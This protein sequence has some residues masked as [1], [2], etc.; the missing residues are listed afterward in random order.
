MDKQEIISLLSNLGLTSYEAKAYV[1][2]L[3][4]GQVNANQVATVAGIPRP[5]IY[6]TIQSL[7]D[8]GL[9]TVIPTTPTE[10]SPIDPDKAISILS[11]K[12]LESIDKLK[13]LLSDIQAKSLQKKVTSNISLFKSLDSL[14]EE[15]KNKVENAK[16]RIDIFDISEKIVSNKELLD[17]LKKKKLN[18]II[19]RFFTIDLIAKRLGSAATEIKLIPPELFHF[20]DTYIVIDSSY[21]I[22]WFADT[23]QADFVGLSGNL[24]AISRLI[25]YLLSTLEE[26]GKEFK[27]TPERVDPIS[28]LRLG[29]AE[30]IITYQRI[31]YI[32]PPIIDY[33]PPSKAYLVL[34]DSRII[35]F[36]AKNMDT[37]IVAIPR[38]FI[39]YIMP[40]ILDNVKYIRIVYQ[41]MGRTEEMLVK[42]ENVD[43]FFRYII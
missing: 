16:L 8:K 23:Q 27:E 6:E 9:V 5:K 33:T 37:K 35:L 30:K 12:Y 38:Q 29:P 15:I 10:Y 1:A 43:L 4:L 21:Y 2:L 41:K 7:V 36:S 14:V 24:E 26:K 11:Q 13:L 34:T 32:N 17:A 28:L 42:L 20:L 3:E 19:I 39:I 18:N 40:V 25:G 31:E 22:I